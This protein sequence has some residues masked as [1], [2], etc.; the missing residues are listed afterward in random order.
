MQIGIISGHKIP[1]LIKDSE[2][3]MVETPF[4]DILVEAFELGEHEIFFINRHGEKSNLPPHKVNYLANI[5]A[6]ASSH[7]ECILSIGTVGSMKKNIQPGYFVVPHDFI[8]FTKSRQQTFFDNKRVHIDMSK[9]FCP[10]LRESLI[11]NCKKTKGVNIHEKGVY[12]ATEG[13]RLETASEIK[14]F[15]NFADIVGM[16]AVPE[17]VLAREKGICY[18]SICVVCNMATGIQNKVTADEISLI[19]KEKE[20]VISEILHLTIDSIDEKRNC[21]CKNDLSKATL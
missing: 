19:Y 9:P 8:D 17:I 7:V 12:L 20:S 5:Q 6:F 18:A 21:N 10:S 14:F 11:K 2:K 15:S 13:P 4:G 16:T 1:D 3:I